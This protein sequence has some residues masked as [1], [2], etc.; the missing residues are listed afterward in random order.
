MRVCLVSRLND[1]FTSSGVGRT[2]AR[3][4]VRRWST[5]RKTMV[6]VLWLCW[7]RKADQGPVRL[8]WIF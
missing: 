5:Y 7:E 8:S 4:V 3:G 2:Y 6:S 1:V